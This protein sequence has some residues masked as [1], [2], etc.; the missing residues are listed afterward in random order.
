M[1]KCTSAV[2]AAKKIKRAGMAKI[3][4]TTIP[5]LTKKS[6]ADGTPTPERLLDLKKVSFGSYPIG[7]E[8]CAE[9]KGVE[10]GLTASGANPK[11]FVVEKASGMHQ[12]PMCGNGIVYEKDDNIE[13]KYIR[14]YK[15]NGK[16]HAQTKSAYINS[17]GDIIN[18]SPEDLAN[19]FPVI[20]PPMKQVLAGMDEEHLVLPISPKAENITY[21]KKG[22]IVFGEED[23]TM[24]KIIELMNDLT[25]DSED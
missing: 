3:A 1:K 8:Y 23:K 17:K 2:E 18:V 14:I 12:D 7:Y 11:D 19:Y 4:M 15:Q 6:R 13:Q 22:T 20:S 9:N 25:S 5:K 16:L 21:L 24:Q 10:R